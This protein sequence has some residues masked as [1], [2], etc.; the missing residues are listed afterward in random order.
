MDKLIFLATVADL[1]ENLTNSDKYIYFYLSD[2]VKFF[3]ISAIVAEKSEIG[4]LKLVWSF[5]IKLDWLCWFMV[6]CENFY[7]VV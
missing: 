6:G 5:L 1:R 2:L 4:Q 7:G 3:F